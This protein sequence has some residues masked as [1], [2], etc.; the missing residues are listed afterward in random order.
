MAMIHATIYAN[1][2]F[3][4]I[5][6][7]AGF[8]R[9]ARNPYEKSHLLEPSAEC[10]QIGSALLDALAR[11]KQLSQS[12]IATF[13]DLTRVERDYAEWVANLKDQF[14]YE[15]KKALFQ[16]MKHCLVR[17]DDR[18]ITVC[19]TRHEKLEAW[20]GTGTKGDDNVIA[21]LGASPDIVGRAVLLALERCQ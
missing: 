14:G 13:F 10:S 19:P 1:P 15:T 8:R 7:C 12:E 18:A 20:S 16:Q 21:E 6:A 3:L 11:Y 4:L 17:A 2:D 5:E 9:V